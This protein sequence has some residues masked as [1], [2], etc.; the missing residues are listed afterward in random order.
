MRN[1][2][3]HYENYDDFLNLWK[4]YIQFFAINYFYIVLEGCFERE[5]TFAMIK[6]TINKDK[7]VIAAMHNAGISS[8]DAVLSDFSNRK[9]NSSKN[10]ELLEKKRIPIRRAIKKFEKKWM[11]LV[12]EREFGIDLGA[13]IER[14][15]K[16]CKEKSI[17]HKDFANR[18]IVVEWDYDEDSPMK[19]NG[20]KPRVWLIDWERRG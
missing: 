16:L 15:K 8:L 17:H 19:K 1:G 13:E 2:Y 9:K 7:D 11:S 6:N 3:P 5:E 12:Y 18:N 14:L 10:V 20:R 4:Q